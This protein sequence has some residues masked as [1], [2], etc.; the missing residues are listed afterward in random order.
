MAGDIDTRNSTSG[1]VLTLA[2][3]VVSWCW[4]LQKVIAFSTTEVEYILVTEASKEVIWLASL[5]SDFG[6]LEKACLGVISL[7]SISA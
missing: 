2:V 1:Y 6:L 4:G 7:H 5:C 3:D